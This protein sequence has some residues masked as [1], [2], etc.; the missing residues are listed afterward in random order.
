MH[1]GTPLWL[2]NSFINA[3]YPEL[4]SEYAQ[5]VAARYKSIVHY[6][7]PLN[8]PMVN[9]DFCGNR[10]EWPP[11]LTGDDGYVKLILA[12]A[13]GIL[14]TTQ[15]LKA[16]QPESVTVQVE[17]L[18][19]TFTKD[20]SLEERAARDNA[21]QYVCFDLTTGRVNEKHA[22][23]GYLCN[24]G[25]TNADMAWFREHA[26]AFD[27]LGANFYPWSY[28]E[29]RQGSHGSVRASRGAPAGDRISIVLREAYKRYRMPMMVT[30]T[31]ANNDHSGRARWMDETIAAVRLLR[32]QGIPV[33]GYTWFPVFSMIDWAYRKGRG[34]IS[35]YLIHLGLYDSA[36]DSQ[37]VL[38]RRETPLVEHYQQHIANSMSLIGN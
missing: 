11:Y 10:A 15:V 30:E 19:H 37:G 33:L 14:L 28:T 1:Y 3:S 17:A 36:F 31:S 34:P 29:L 5:K 13:K 12:L 24:H 23:A 18:W 21:R 20:S 26:V 16:E 6:Y 35:K 27:I 8:E 25:M 4:V 32:A 9:A 2:E 38:R 7:T 22:L